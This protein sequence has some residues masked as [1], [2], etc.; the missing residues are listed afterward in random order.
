M[1]PSEDDCVF[2]NVTQSESDPTVFNIDMEIAY[3]PQTNA[4]D[5]IMEKVRVSG[6]HRK[7]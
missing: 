3:A 7:I 4:T 6:W 5:E 2:L 1:G